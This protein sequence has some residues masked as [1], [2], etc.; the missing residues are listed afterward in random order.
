[1]NLSFG[2]VDPGQ[3]KA[4]NELIG[5]RT[6]AGTLESWSIEEIRQLLGEIE[7]ELRRRPI[8]HVER[9]DGGA[10]L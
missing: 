4:A 9:T 10:L 6:V 8:P 5:E 7:A 3:I 1:L 2:N